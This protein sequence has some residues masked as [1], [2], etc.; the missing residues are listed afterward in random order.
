L[1]GKGGRERWRGIKKEEEW[2]EERKRTQQQQKDR[3]RGGKERLLLS[4]RKEEIRKGD[5][6]SAKYLV[7]MATLCLNF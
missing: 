5:L 7:V 6:V 4:E 1:D 3:N 2:K